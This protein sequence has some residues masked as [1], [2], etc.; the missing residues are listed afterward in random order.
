MTDTILET[1]RQKADAIHAAVKNEENCMVFV[2]Y[3]IGW[4]TGVKISQI[5][6]GVDRLDDIEMS[7][8]DITNTLC[9]KVK[10]ND[11]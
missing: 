9:F 10:P 1:P 8:T 4:V 6:I 5:S 11:D 3:P 7:V 2:P